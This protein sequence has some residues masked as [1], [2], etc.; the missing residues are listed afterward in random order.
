MREKFAHVE[1]VCHRLFNR[2]APQVSELIHKSAEYP[3]LDYARVSVFFQEI[4]DDTASEDAYAVVAGSQFC[5]TR[6]AH[7]NN[8]SKYYVDAAAS[9]FTEVTALLKA[10][11]IDL[12]N[13]RFLI[14]QGE[15]EQIAMMK[16]KAA[17]AGE[18]GLLEYLEDIVGSNAYVPRIAEAEKVVEALTGDRSEKLSRVKVVERERNALEGAKAEAEALLRE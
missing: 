9:S 2:W 1:P 7:R 17:S 11:G 13:N 16:P 14:L 4:I 8:S 6:T 15:V 3:D 18:E 5:V 10:R 12:D